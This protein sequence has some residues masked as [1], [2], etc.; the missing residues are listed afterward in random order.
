MSKNTSAEPCPWCH[1]EPDVGW[2]YSMATG[3]EGWRVHCDNDK[4]PIS[5]RGKIYRHRTRAVAAWN[6]WRIDR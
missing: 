4:C 1:R 6:M 5:P 3:R 2:T